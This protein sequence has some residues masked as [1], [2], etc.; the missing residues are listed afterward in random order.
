MSGLG[1]RKRL[2]EGIK[3]TQFLA[4]DCI[5]FTVDRLYCDGGTPGYVTETVVLLANTL[6]FEGR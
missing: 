3:S 6:L 2:K 5:S 4:I 1:Y